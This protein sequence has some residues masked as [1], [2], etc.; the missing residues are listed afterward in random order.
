MTE[1]LQ[2]P[3]ATAGKKIQV[4]DPRPG[5]TDVRAHK[6]VEIFIS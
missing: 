1:L 3:I 2:D 5:A 6:N 4:T